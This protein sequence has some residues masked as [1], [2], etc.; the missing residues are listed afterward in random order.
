MKNVAAG[1]ARKEQRKYFTE[2]PLSD[3]NED[4]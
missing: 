4:V 2:K 3:E 1:S